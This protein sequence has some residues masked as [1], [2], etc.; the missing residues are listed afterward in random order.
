MPNNE[1]VIIVINKDFDTNM[2]KIYDS[3]KT[4]S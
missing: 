4:I 2:L 1:L 3:N